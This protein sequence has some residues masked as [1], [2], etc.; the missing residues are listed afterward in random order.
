MKRDLIVFEEPHIDL[1]ALAE[2]WSSLMQMLNRSGWLDLMGRNT[3]LQSFVMHNALPYLGEAVYPKPEFAIPAVSCKG[4][5]LE[6]T[7]KEF[8]NDTF[9]QLRLFSCSR[10][11]RGNILLVAPLSGHWSTMLRDTITA[12]VGEYDVYLVDWKNVR[13]IPITSGTF[14]LSDYVELMRKYFNLLAEKGIFHVVAVCQ[15]TVPVA[16]ALALQSKCNGALP[17]SAVMMGGPIDTRLNPTQVNKFA[18]R[19]DLLWFANNSTHPVPRKYAGAGREVL[20]G[21]LQLRGFLAVDPDR[22]TKAYRIYHDDLFTGNKEGAERHKIFYDEYFAV[23]D[24]PA[25]YFLETIEVVFIEHLLPKGEW[26][27]NG[28]RVSLGDIR[29]VKLLT[30]EGGLDTIVGAEQ[31]HALMHHTPQI[32]RKDKITRTVPGS[33]HY[34]LFAGSGF[35]QVIYPEVISPFLRN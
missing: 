7:E 17:Q 29:G 25:E 9:C 20:P 21:S 28:E 31:T 6:V 23:M 14:S 33:G 12:F 26:L 10:N 16:A 18:S 4:G 30:I 35:T 13:D 8:L 27:V 11:S 2:V 24:L 19:H 3:L 22:H 5:K 15:P 1:Y 32:K 34:G